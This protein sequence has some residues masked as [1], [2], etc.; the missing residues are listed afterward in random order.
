MRAE[1][2]ILISESLRLTAVRM[3][4]LLLNTSCLELGP[5]NFLQL[6]SLR[7]FG[8]SR[9]YCRDFSSFFPF[10]PL[11]AL[12]QDVAVLYPFAAQYT[13]SDDQCCKPATAS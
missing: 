8:P 12:H 6:S 5:G 7:S 10:L 1:A 2:G 3:D 13:R 11:C 9:E 4:F